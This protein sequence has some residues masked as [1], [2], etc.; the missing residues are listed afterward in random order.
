MLPEDWA[1]NETPLPLMMYFHG[2]GN[3]PDEG[4]RSINAASAK[5]FMTMSMTG[6]GAPDDYN[7]W[8]G[9]GS[10]KSPGEYGRTCNEGSPD[11][12]YEDCGSCVDDC[13]W[14]TCLDSV[15]QTLQQLNTILDEF[16]IDMSM[17]W[18]LGCSNG[19]MFSYS[20]AHDERTRDIIAGIV[21]QVGL[22]HWGF[23]WG[24]GTVMS[25]SGMWGKKDGTCPPFTGPADNGVEYE[26]RSS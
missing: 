9:F 12:C 20:L 14:T 8:N 23:N 18:P 25:Y 5:G 10:T 6:M 3:G 17:I 16:C 11:Y 2:W 7:S 22:P 19:G 4:T 1:G 24:P 21:P 26:C 13:W 15:D